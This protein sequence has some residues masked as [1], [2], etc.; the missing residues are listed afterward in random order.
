MRSYSSA[1]WIGLCIVL[2][3]AGAADAASSRV[4]GGSS[5][6]FYNCANGQPMYIALKGAD[7][8]VRN[9]A[10][11][12]PGGHVVIQVSKGEM[13]SWSC[14]GPVSASSYFAYATVH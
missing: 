4:T 2:A 9:V 13:Q 11:L 14:G 8:N 3:G 7:G 5:D 6:W 10:T 12:G 1:L